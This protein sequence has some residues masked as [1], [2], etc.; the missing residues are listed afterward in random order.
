MAL[1]VRNE[2]G[3]RGERGPQGVVRFSSPN[4]RSPVTMTLRTL[5]KKSSGYEPPLYKMI[6]LR[7][8][9]PTADHKQYIIDIIYRPQMPYLQYMV[10]IACLVNFFNKMQPTG[11]SPSKTLRLLF[12]TLPCRNSLLP[13]ARPHPGDM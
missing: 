12:A 6:R 3:D 9:A 5:L 1:W 8:R 7:D 11:I 10:L 2:S 4:Y 13:L